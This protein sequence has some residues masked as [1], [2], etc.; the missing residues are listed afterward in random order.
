MRVTKMTTARERPDMRS[1]R[2]PTSTTETAHQSGKCRRCGGFLVDDHSMDLDIRHSEGRF[3][4]WAMRCLQCGDIIDETILRNRH[5]PHYLLQEDLLRVKGGGD[6][7]LLDDAPP[8]VMKY[9]AL[10]F[11]MRGWEKD[12]CDG[13]SVGGSLDRADDPQELWP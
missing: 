9:A 3:S 7:S 2:R 10:H 11:L 12:R 1:A 8:T 13:S 4:L 6:P 5:F